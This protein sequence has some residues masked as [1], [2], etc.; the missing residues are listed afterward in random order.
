MP[1]DQ[2]VLQLR[3][4]TC[5]GCVASVTRALERVPGV[6]RAVV[7]LDPPRAVIDRDPGAAGTPAL[8]EAAAN[9]GFDAE[10]AAAP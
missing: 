3:G 10:I 9:A 1:T 2:V 4:M 8:I 6:R 5:G 7:T